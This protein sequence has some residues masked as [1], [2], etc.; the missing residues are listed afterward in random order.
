MALIH[1]WLLTEN[2]NDSVGTLNLTNNGG[3]TFSSDG[4]SFSGTAQWLSGTYNIPANATLSCWVKPTTWTKDMCVMY[5]FHAT[6]SGVGISASVAGVI[7]GE[8]A[9]QNTA[10]SSG[11]FTSSSFPSD[12]WTLITFSA[13]SSAVLYRN[14]SAIATATITPSASASSSFAIG[15]YGGTNFNHYEYQGKI[16][17]ARIYEYP[18]LSAS[19][20]SALY[21]AGPNGLTAPLRLA[22]VF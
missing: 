18:P 13:G 9:G 6:S 19:E 3:V 8:V 16:I 11:H 20:V 15:A 10:T 12:Q 21:S 4:A 14:S 1:R 22:Q 2:A 5:S 17:D 7:N